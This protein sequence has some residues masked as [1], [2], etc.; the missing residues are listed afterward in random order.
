M[1]TDKKRIE[2]GEWVDCWICAKVFARRRETMRYCHTCERG[3]CEG[4]HGS[5]SRSVATCVICATT[6][7]QGI[8]RAVSG[9]GNTRLR[10]V[11]LAEAIGRIKAVPIEQAMAA[12]EKATDE[13]RKTWR[14]DAKVKSVL[15]TIRAE[16]AARAL[17]EADE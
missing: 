15:A 4:E 12:V 8:R 9:E 13:Q 5:Y 1:T 17:E 6:K 10:L 3:F 14:S 7:N 2:Q 16:A 11:E